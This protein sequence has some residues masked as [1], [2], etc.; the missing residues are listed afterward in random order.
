MEIH[1]SARRHG[2]AD[3]GIE[4]ALAHA[5]TWVELG[6]DPRRYLLAGPGR[7]GNLLEL[8]VLDLGGEELVIHAMGL[9]RSTDQEL[10]GGE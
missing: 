7:T 10:F 4:H 3:E 8:V 9:R 6:D 1:E 5:V 2:V